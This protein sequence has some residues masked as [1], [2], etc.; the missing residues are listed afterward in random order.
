M[1]LSNISLRQLRIFLA[2]AEH[3]GFSRA[4]NMVGLTQSAMS[5]SIR[6]LENEL[7]IKL[8]DR[9]TREVFLT[10]EGQ[11]LSGELRRLMGELEATFNNAWSRGNS[12]V[13]WYMSQPVQLSLPGS[14][15]TV[16]KS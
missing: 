16:L 3:Q 13:G 7:G 9:T 2:V 12:T 5:H 15:R 14:C 6:D 11:Y 10:Q 1:N 8:F 4:G